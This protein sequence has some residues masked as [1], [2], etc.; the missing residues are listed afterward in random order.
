NFVTVTQEG[1]FSWKSK[2]GSERIV[3][4]RSELEGLIKDAFD[5]DENPN[6]DVVTLRID[7][8][9]I[10]EDVAFV[11]DKVA[12]NKGQIIFMTEKGN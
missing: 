5:S 7:K 9:V 10:F 11:M 2:G 12:K 4:D 1:T 3:E 8:R 6:N